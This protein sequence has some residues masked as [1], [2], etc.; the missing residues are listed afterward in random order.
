M[1]STLRVLDIFE[2][3]A[4]R[5]RPLTLSQ[6]AEAVSAPVSS[7]YGVVK[8]ME[9]R[10]YLHCVS[11]R[12]DWY[13]TARMLQNTKEIEEGESLI[14][15]FLPVLTEL[16]NVTRE[17]IIVGQAANANNS[18]IY[19]SVLEGLQ[20]I[21]YTAE[22][23]DRK[24]LHSTAIGKVVLG[25]MTDDARMKVLKRLKLEAVTSETFSEPELVNK[26]I[27]AGLER[28]YQMTKGENVVDVGAIAMPLRRLGRTFGIAIAGPVHRLVPREADLAGLLKAAC[29]KLADADT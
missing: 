1:T 22:V 27:L 11:D 13:P 26:D 17:T 14:A 21:K 20:A 9:E 15:R 29:E 5:K 19:L 24:P 4:T 23:G 18:I 6:L 25:A 12:K 28:G 3:F 10:G 16:R 8:A 7:C 2:A